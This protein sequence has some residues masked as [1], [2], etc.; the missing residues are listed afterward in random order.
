MK[1]LLVEDFATMRRIIRDL[2][3]EIGYHH[4]IEA[5]NGETALG[6]LHNEAVDLV[7]SDLKMPDISGLELLQAIRADHRLAHMPVMIITAD[8][9][10]ENILA[11]ARAG[12]NAYIIKPFTAAILETKIRQITGAV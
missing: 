9:Q 3:A 4:I 1:I 7:I 5:E 10:R 11:A 2:L 12:V 8:A 6:I